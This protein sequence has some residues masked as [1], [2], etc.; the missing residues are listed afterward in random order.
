[1]MNTIIFG[2]MT[3]HIFNGTNMYI[4]HD[5]KG[6]SAVYDY[7]RPSVRD[8]TKAVDRNKDI[9]K[10]YKSF[11][12]EYIE[13]WVAEYPDSDLSNFLYNLKNLKIYECTKDENTRSA[14]SANA[15]ACYKPTDN[16]I[17]VNKEIN[18]SDRSLDDYIV[19]AHKD[20]GISVQ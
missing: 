19:L 7:S 18:L 5:A 13:D 8:L 20:L 4:I 12:K 2:Q 6:Y 10:R 1:M 11:I 16:T 3:I 9:P 17:F 14:L 15:I